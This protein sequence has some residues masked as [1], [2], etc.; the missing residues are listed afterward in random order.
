MSSAVNLRHA[1]PETHAQTFRIF[2]STLFPNSDAVDSGLR[3][4]NC[5]LFKN[6]AQ[7]ILSKCI[8]PNHVKNLL[9]SSRNVEPNHDNK[10]SGELK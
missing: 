6:R 8:E 10:K 3:Y 1:M 9:F 4:V 7:K 5:Y 2:T